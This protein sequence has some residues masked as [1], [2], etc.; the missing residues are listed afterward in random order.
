[1]TLL[2]H[3]NPIIEIS[4]AGY[5]EMKETILVV[6]DDKQMLDAIA[7]VLDRA[8]HKDISLLTDPLLV[9][10]I[11]KDR[12]AACMILDLSFPGVNGEDI[13]SETV[14]S[15]PE[16]PVIVLT[17]SLD[18]DTV[19]RCMKAGAADYL[20]KPVERER[21]LSSVKNLLTIARLSSENE[22]LRT[23]LM[24]ESAG[25]GFF[26]GFISE[27]ERIKSIFG[28]I[29]KAA[30]TSFPFLITRE[31]GTGKELIA[32]GIHDASGRTGKFIAVN[33]SGLD[34]SAL[35]DSLFGHVKGAFTSAVL[36]R[37]GLIREASNGTLFLD[38]IGD[39]S[40][41]TQ[42]K[43]LRL[44]QSGEYYALGSDTCMHSNAR[45]VTATNRN[46]D[47]LIRKDLFRNDLYYRL[48]THWV[49]IPPLRKRR[50][51]IPILLNVLIKRAAGQMGKPAPSYPKELAI[52][53]SQYDFPGNVRELEGMVQD[54]VASCSRGMLSLEPFR[55]RILN[56][57][58]NLTFPERRKELL[59]ISDEHFPSIDEVMENLILKAMKR[60]SGNQ[61]IAASMLGISRQ[62]LS[63]KLKTFRE[64]GK[65][66]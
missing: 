43:L 16:I 57:E 25:S 38:E 28:Y 4:N 13:L 36:S 35:S 47:E 32:K 56:G 51:D 22:I 1:L 2:S 15:H 18:T 14:Q 66:L 60:S 27:D 37:N 23:H 64:K 62:T 17:S 20:T 59:N 8:G 12:S 9:R 26:S 6:D 3:D 45:I 29:E 49:D 24:K 11:L 63:S 61:G 34:D 21:L 42:M 55:K 40:P 58:D 19:V 33:T 52:L 50:G 30:V 53:L 10:D 5:L 46:L 41:A 39:I 54:A 65:S 31:T 48:R 44:L 7:K